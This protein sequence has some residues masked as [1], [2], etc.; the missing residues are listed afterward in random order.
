[1]RKADQELRRLMEAKET[2]NRLIERLQTYGGR[3]GEL[4]IGLTAKYLID[5]A[6]DYLLTL[7]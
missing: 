6:F 2:K 4:S 5:R 3:G 7:L 1:M